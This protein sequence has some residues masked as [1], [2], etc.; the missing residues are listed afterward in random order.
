M[1]S[2]KQLNA[3]GPVDFTLRIRSLGK[4]FLKLCLAT[5][6][7]ELRITLRENIRAFNS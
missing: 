5:S 1:S 4:S 7:V 3:E 2:T 6:R